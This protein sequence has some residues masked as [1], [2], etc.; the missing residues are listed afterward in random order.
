MA[1]GLLNFWQI[2]K[3]EEELGAEFFN[4]KQNLIW[5]KRNNIGHQWSVCGVLETT[6]DQ[7]KS[8]WRRKGHGHMQ[9]HRDSDHQLWTATTSFRKKRKAHD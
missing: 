9:R 5:L 6:R 8:K 1:E 2:N 7:K 3:S 4:D